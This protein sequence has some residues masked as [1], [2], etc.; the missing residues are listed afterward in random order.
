MATKQTLL[1][2]IDRF[3]PEL[4][5]RFLASVQDIKD[6]ARI[7]QIQAALEAGNINAA[8][9]AL[10]LEPAAM[11]PLT[12]ATE[13]AFETGGI[14][15]ASQFQ[16]PSSQAAFRFDVRNSRAEATLRG[17]TSWDQT[18]TDDQFDMIRDF[19][20]DGMARG[21]NPRQMALDLV[22]RID[23]ATGRRTGGIIG[24]NNQQE[25]YLANARR[26]LAALHDDAE[27]LARYKARTLR[28]ARFDS[29]VNKAAKNGT[30]L[31]QTQIDQLSTRYSDNL[32]QWR[33]ETIARDQSI[34]AL[35]SAQQEATQQLID[36]GAVDQQDIQ[37]EWDATGDNRTRETHRDMDGQKVGLDEPFISPSGARMMFPG[38]SS[39]GAPP[40]ETIQCRC[41]VRLRIDYIRKARS[42]Q[43]ATI[44]S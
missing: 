12:A 16:R 18:F 4:R 9:N 26:E 36:S 20:N 41:R 29:V 24:L 6:Q 15:T 2:L 1:D 33:G 39:L 37:R 30:P 22:G 32:L 8:I 23:K 44:A 34:K 35:N 38:D 25:R 17:I 3:T 11:R 27:A 43:P 31:T 42:N 28:D 10:G 21:I 19:L 7:S 13:Q 40:E 5:R 14:F